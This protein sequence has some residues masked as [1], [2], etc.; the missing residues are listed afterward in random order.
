MSDKLE[1]FEEKKP[2]V[3]TERHWVA[4]RVDIYE[5]DAELLL[6]ADVPGV[7]KSNLKIHMDKDQLLIEGLQE[8]ETAGNALAREY[9]T[10]D[11]RRS[12]L[13]PAGIDATKISADLKQGVLYLHLPKSEALKPRQ[14]EVKAG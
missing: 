5:N 9:Q 13:L 7:N 4:P 12:F 2:E 11:Y 10:V 6:L 8:E 1:K 14:I 3:V